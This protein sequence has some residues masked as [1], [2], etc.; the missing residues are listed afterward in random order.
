MASRRDKRERLDRAS[1]PV[2][3]DE[4]FEQYSYQRPVQPSHPNRTSNLHDATHLHPRKPRLAL[5]LDPDALGLV[6]VD[7][8][9]QEPARVLVVRLELGG[10]TFLVAQLW[11]RARVGQAGGRL[12]WE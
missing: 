12:G 6:L 9:R 4:S 7:V 11:V 10:G 2:R 3:S 1:R 8:A 5:A